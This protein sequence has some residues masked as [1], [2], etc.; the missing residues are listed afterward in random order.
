LSGGKETQAFI[1]RE[2]INDIDVGD[3]SA[4]KDT[5]HRILQEA[6]SIEIYNYNVASIHCLALPKQSFSASNVV[7]LPQPDP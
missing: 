6:A 2:I 3:R 4:P 5:F 1:G 7:K